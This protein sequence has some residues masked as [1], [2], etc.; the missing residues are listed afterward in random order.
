M[1]KSDTNL[2]HI[3][4]SRARRE[5]RKP[6]WTDD[7]E[8]VAFDSETTEGD[9][10]MIST[11]SPIGEKLYENDGQVLEPEKIFD[12]L[13]QKY[14]RSNLNVWFNLGFDAEVILK[15]LDSYALKRLQ[16]ANQV[17]V[18]IANDFKVIINDEDAYA[19]HIHVLESEAEKPYKIT[20]L[21]NK[22]LKIADSNNNNYEYFDVA[23]LFRN[24]LE[25]A[26]DEWLDNRDM[27]KNEEGV[28]AAKFDDK[29]YIEDNYDSI[30]R[31][32]KRDAKLTRLITERLVRVAEDIDIPCGKPYSTGYLAEGFLQN[33]LEKKPGWGPNAMQKMAWDSYAGG[34]F[35]VFER[36]SVGQVAGPDINSAYPA[37]MAELPDPGT[38]SWE[39]HLNPDIQEI[40]EADY[41]FVKAKVWTDS[42]KKIQ[43]FA[44][45][46]DKVV[47]Y[48]VL[49]GFTN[50]C[51]KDI[52]VWAYENGYI[53]NFEIERCLLANE[54]PSTKFPFDFFDSLYD[55]R[56]TWEIELAKLKRAL[57]L[58]IVLNSMYGKTAQTQYRNHVPD[59]GQISANDLA[60]NERLKTGPNNS[61]PHIRTQHAG[62][63]FNPFLASYITGLTRLE[64]H[65]QVE[66]HNLVDNTILFATDCIMVEADAYN[67]SNF[68]NLIPDS[69]TS[70]AEQLGMWDFDYEGDAFVVGSGVYDV[71]KSDGNFKMATRG[72]REA[73]L[74]SLREAA[75][76]ASGSGITLEHNRPRTLGEAVHQKKLG[77]EDIGQFFEGE[78]DL[79]PDFDNKRNW[80][81]KS[82]S[83]D[84]LLN[85]SESSKPL[86]ISD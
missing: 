50:T 29:S 59:D 65:K 70:Y 19:E 33:H 23:Q 6:K 1:T 86:S 43:P 13:T 8:I 80:E 48:P 52:F 71:Q 27:E 57:L 58:K 62:G 9:I 76:Q 42:E 31:Y 61:I 78:R 35:E 83:W 44:I 38:L 28:N 56:K 49:N 39:L 5:L 82:P 41:G 60:E 51:L 36:G 46:M 77:N 10:F 32:A 15:V 68:D 73:Q 63:L 18:D 75:R 45:K 74:P 17:K 55:K 22:Y 7:K 40:R 66:A 85:F 69:N 72:F 24:S 84:E 14:F 30:C 20:Y 16:V 79:E 4:T 37:V 47:K 34:R 3:D 12:V 81:R 53:E 67:Q 25:G 2:E 26:V 11:S 64:L 54:L 21:P